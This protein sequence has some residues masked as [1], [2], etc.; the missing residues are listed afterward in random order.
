MECVAISCASSNEGAWGVTTLQKTKVPI[1][2][3]KDFFKE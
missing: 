3:I 1:N 2:L